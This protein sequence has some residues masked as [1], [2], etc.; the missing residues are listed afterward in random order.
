MAASAT[1]PTLL[2]VIEGEDIILYDLPKHPLTGASVV[3]G[4]VGASYTASVFDLDSA[5]PTTDLLAETG[6]VTT[7]GTSNVD[8]TEPIMQTAVQAATAT[9]GPGAASQVPGGTYSVLYQVLAAD[10]SSALEGGHRYRVEILFTLTA[11][12]PLYSRWL[13]TVAAQSVV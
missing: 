10:L 9:Y 3:S 1:E 2:T 11:G 6:T 5:T 13:V 12:G 4:S 8:A 7:A